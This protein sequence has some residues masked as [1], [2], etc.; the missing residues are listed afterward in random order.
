MIGHREAASS[1]TDLQTPDFS[2]AAHA[3]SCGPSPASP[4][5]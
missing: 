1:G 5:L 2:P 3:S 4:G